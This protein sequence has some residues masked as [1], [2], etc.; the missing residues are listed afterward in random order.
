VTTKPAETT[1][2]L[3][4]PLAGIRVVAVEQSVAGPLA[5]RLL[6]DMGADVVKVEP[7]RGDFSRRWDSH[8]HG[9]SSHFAWLNRRKR[10]IALNLRDAGD[11]EV[12]DRLLAG[13]DVLV[14]NLAP[15]AARRA[16]L[17][18]ERLR[19]AFPSLV[20]CQITGYGTRGP[21]RDRKAYDMLLQ[22]ESGILGLTGDADG[23]VRVGVSVCDIGTGLYAATLLLAALFE[24]QST[25]DGR[26]ID[27]SMF[28]AMTEFA[29]P[30]LTAFANAGLRY[31]RNRSRH[32]NIVPYGV[33]ECS[34]GFIAIA[35]EHDG[36]WRTFC[37][38]VLGQPNLAE[39]PTLAS[40]EQRVAARSRVEA[41]VE[42]AIVGRP[43]SYWK[44]LMD[45][46]G[47]AYGAINEIDEVWEHA[48]ERGLDL[49]GK[50]K[51][52]DGRRVAVPRSPAERAFGRDGV[53]GLPSIDGDRAAIL[54]ALDELESPG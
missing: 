32:H 20:T 46:A 3:P 22:A 6:A 19:P 25:G 34:D 50:A 39:D 37:E 26:F 36:E 49:H 23:P 48:V 54:S 2:E 11:A 51:L 9:E 8:V 15:A 41:L 1:T 27:L 14:F 29:G 21:M 24:R 44:A 12:L 5:S 38:D 35:I 7:P 53:A 40:N 31:P 28:E 10:S 13:A 30:N 17:T 33:F 18:P 4:G 52:G 43:R 42:D 47:I 16:G 45:A